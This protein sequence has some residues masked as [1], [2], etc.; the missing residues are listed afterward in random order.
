[1]AT[2]KVKVNKSELVRQCITKNPK[3]STG[4]VAEKL[5][6][7]GVTYGLVANVKARLGGGKKK[8]NKRAKTS[9][10]M[11]GFNQLVEHLKAAK[12]FVAVCGDHNSAV[13]ALESLA[14]IADL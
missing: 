10:A 5:K 11:K 13:S 7:S 1:M 2:K 14:K 6:K 12:S 8:P 4:E 9:G 3:L